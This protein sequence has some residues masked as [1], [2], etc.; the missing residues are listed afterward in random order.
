MSE[1]LHP[2]YLM[3]FNGNITAISGPLE[4]L[5]FHYYIIFYPSGLILDIQCYDAS[6]P[7]QYRPENN[8]IKGPAN[9]S[10]IPPIMT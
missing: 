6:L 7:I 5:R 1:I 9:S 2:D 4:D 10:Y 8:S 3:E